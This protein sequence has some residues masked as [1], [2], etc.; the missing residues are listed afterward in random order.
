MPA[1]GTTKDVRGDG[2]VLMSQESQG[3]DARTDGEITWVGEQRLMQGYCGRADGAAA[4]SKT[5]PPTS[6]PAQASGP[7]G[8]GRPV[9][10]V[11]GR[12][13]RRGAVLR[14]APARPVAPQ[15]ADA[16]A[17]PQRAA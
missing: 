9:A 6:A 13:R 5:T 2:V 3:Q 16:E 17:T 8:A 15:D 14:V 1:A 7:P 10:A 11:R 4:A 12:P